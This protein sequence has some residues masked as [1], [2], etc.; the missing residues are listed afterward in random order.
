[1]CSG[2]DKLLP[3]LQSV[4]H[5]PACKHESN[6]QYLRI[7]VL[8]EG[9]C[10]PLGFF[11]QSILMSRASTIS[12]F[13]QHQSCLWQLKTAVFLHWCLIHGV[14]LTKL[15][16]I[17]PWARRWA[18]WPVH[19]VSPDPKRTCWPRRGRGTPSGRFPGLGW[20]PPRLNVIKRYSSFRRR[21]YKAWCW[22]Q[23]SFSGSSN[24]WRE[25]NQGAIR[26]SLTIGF[27]L[28]RNI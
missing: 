28:T 4:E 16:R 7:W 18:R 13:F 14:P 25:S 9:F 5:I 20:L 12:S 6:I 2:G 24:I 22:T 19:R 17:I 23:A 21:D 15:I 11:Q 10:K 3:S 26:C 27:D 1:V 8:T